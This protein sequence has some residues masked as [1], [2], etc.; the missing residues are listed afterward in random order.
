MVSRL[1]WAA[2]RGS[3]QLSQSGALSQACIHQSLSVSTHAKPPAAWKQLWASQKHAWRAY[4]ADT[5]GQQGFNR[6]KSILEQAAEAEMRK[7]KGA[8]AQSTAPPTIA[9]RIFG[10]L[11]DSVMLGTV[12]AA[13]FAGYYTYAYK[14]TTELET[15]LQNARQSLGISPPP[16][17]EPTFHTPPPPP[18]PGQVLSTT[19]GNASYFKSS[20]HPSFH[21]LPIGLLMN[22]QSGNAQRLCPVHHRS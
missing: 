3:K 19:S 22:T 9:S 11:V 8:A 1:I 7:A 21:S 16:D 17:R 2:A 5:A 4:S 18:P 13:A 15:E 14:N 6:T 12:G 20:F 10:I